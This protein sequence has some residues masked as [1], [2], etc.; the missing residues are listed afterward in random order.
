L[1][2]R[3]VLRLPFFSTTKTRE[4]AQK[5]GVDHLERDGLGGKMPILVAKTMGVAVILGNCSLRKNS[6]LR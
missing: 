2:E 6:F 1:K 3:T 4:N 5:Q